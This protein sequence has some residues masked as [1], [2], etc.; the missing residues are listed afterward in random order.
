MNCVFRDVLRDGTFGDVRRAPYVDEAD[1]PL[2]DEPTYETRL[3]AEQV[4]RLVAGQE[5]FR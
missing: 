5:P 4:G 2:S 1:A 3:A